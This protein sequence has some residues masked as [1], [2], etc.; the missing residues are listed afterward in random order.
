MLGRVQGSPRAADLSLSMPSQPSK[1]ASFAQGAVREFLD[2]G[3]FRLEE[4]R[5]QVGAA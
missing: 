1:G 2:A 3:A 5:Q 4:N